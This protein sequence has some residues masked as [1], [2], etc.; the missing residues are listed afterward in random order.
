MFLVSQRFENFAE[1]TTRSMDKHES[2]CRQQTVDLCYE[3]YL[4]WIQTSISLQKAK[5]SSRTDTGDVP[6]A[7]LC[8]ALYCIVY[9]RSED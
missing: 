1:L 9:E 6:S 7:G 2:W 3:L 4:P 8:L 5:R